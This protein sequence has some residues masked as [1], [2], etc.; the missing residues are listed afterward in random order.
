MFQCDGI[1]DDGS[2]SEPLTPTAEDVPSPMWP[3]N[4]CSDHVSSREKL[5]FGALQEKLK[6]TTV[7]TNS[8]ETKIDTHLQDNE[9]QKHILESPPGCSI[10]PVDSSRKTKEKDNSNNITC[11][12]QNGKQSHNSNKIDECNLSTDTRENVDFPWPWY[13]LFIVCCEFWGN[14]S[15]MGPIWFVC[16]V[17]SMCFISFVLAFPLSSDK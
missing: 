8:M 10:K 1:S 17:A 3:D 9:T 13:I 11:T 7:N 12:H 5:E 2:L 6:S 15:Y 14:A 16:Y 4:S